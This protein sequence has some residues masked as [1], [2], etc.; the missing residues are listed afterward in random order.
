MNCAGEK[1]A[2]IREQKLEL[3]GVR[4]VLHKHLSV[5][6]KSPSLSMCLILVKEKKRLLIKVSFTY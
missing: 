4:L 2:R 3:S 6:L 1:T 5:V